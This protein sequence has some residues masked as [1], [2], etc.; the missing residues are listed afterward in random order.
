MRAAPSPRPTPLLRP[1][2]RELRGPVPLEDSRWLIFISPL[3]ISSYRACQLNGAGRDAGELATR[4]AHKVDVN[5]FRAY[6][7]LKCA[8]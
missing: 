2:H 4:R 1:F 7:L 8:G 6:N 5:K 3:I